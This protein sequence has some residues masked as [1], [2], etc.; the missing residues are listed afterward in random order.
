MSLFQILYFHNHITL[1]K[2]GKVVS[3][4]FT[5]TRLDKVV[6]L[7]LLFPHSKEA[8][9]RITCINEKAQTVLIIQVKAYFTIW[10][11]LEWKQASSSENLYEY[12]K[13]KILKI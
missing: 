3:Y 1:G 7:I 9:Q 12:T 11:W 2:V 8:R 10:N 5:I 13:I 4:V 6:L